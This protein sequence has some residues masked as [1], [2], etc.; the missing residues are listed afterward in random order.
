MFSLLVSL[1]QEK[2]DKWWITS[3]FWQYCSPWRR[4]TLHTRSKVNV[5][6]FDFFLWKQSTATEAF[7]LLICKSVIK[8]HVTHLIKL[9]PLVRWWS[10]LHYYL[11]L[12]HCLLNQQLEMIWSQIVFIYLLLLFLLCFW[13]VL[14]SSY[15][16]FPLWQLLWFLTS[17]LPFFVSSL[18]TL[19][20]LLALFW[21]CHKIPGPDF[22]FSHFT[23]LSNTNT[24]SK[25][26]YLTG[27][28]LNIM[29]TSQKSVYFK[30]K[31]LF[32]YLLLAIA[33]GYESIKRKKKIFNWPFCDH[34][35]EGRPY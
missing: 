8:Q 9:F 29:I 2:V 31:I 13:S 30:V 10:N 15:N 1:M 23:Y 26:A 5:W 3:W 24:K 33:F 21:L 4:A 34:H 6:M 22:Y 17:F 14:S 12:P 11:L 20:F 35:W 32:V 27:T 19:A 25:Y 28:K 18:K 16:L 7:N